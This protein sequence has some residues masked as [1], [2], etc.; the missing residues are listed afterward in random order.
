MN[1]RV[2]RFRVLVSLA[3]LGAAFHTTVVQAGQRVVY[4]VPARTTVVVAPAPRAVVVAPAPVVVARLPAGYIAVL[5]AGYRIVVVGG[6][7]YYFVGGIH[8]RAEFYQ[9]RTCYVRVNPL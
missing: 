8:Y 7:R 1:A 6:A 3:V 2:S 4:G 9:G 5:P